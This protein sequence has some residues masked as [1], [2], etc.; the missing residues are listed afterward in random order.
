[1]IK[2]SK[3]IGIV[4]RMDDLGRVCLP[5]E[6]RKAM[7]LEP[8]DP[9]EI[10]PTSDGLMLTPYRPDE[11]DF[12]TVEKV[13]DHICG[14]GNYILFD[15]GGMSILPIANQYEMGGSLDATPVCWGGE[16]IGYLSS[17]CENCEGAADLVAALLC[18]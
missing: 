3:T 12:T 10:V 2:M 16:C 1:M 13:L 18:D 5:K 8:G 7:C 6:L 15:A 14:K 17:P 11:P 4:R 9:V